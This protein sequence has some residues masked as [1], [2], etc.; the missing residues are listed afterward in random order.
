MG[1][2]YCMGMENIDK[3]RTMF[4]DKLINISLNTLINLETY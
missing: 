1:F 2:T 4:L 3:L